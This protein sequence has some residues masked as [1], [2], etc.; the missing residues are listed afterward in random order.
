MGDFLFRSQI[1]CHS[2]TLPGESKTFDLKTRATAPVRYDISNHMSYLDY[3]V[4]KLT[5][6]KEAEFR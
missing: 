5:G 2:P 4:S 3:K 6:T 1:D